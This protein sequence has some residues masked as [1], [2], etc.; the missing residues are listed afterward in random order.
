LPIFENTPMPLFADKSGKRRAPI[1]QRSLPQAGESLSDT[2]RERWIDMIFWAVLPIFLGTLCLGEWIRFW[3]KAPPSPGVATFVFV[4]GSGFCGWRALRIYR[5]LT[6]SL[7]AIRGERTVGELLETLR[8][9]GYRVFHD[10]TQEG[11][12]ID[13]AI[14]GPAGV[15]S[16]ETKTHSKPQ[17]GNPSVTFDGETILI[18]GFKPDR[19]PVVQAKASAGRVRKILLD[20]TGV[21][22]RVM[23]V[24][25]YPGW[26]V[27]SSV[28][29]DDI[30]VTNPKYFSKWIVGRSRKLSDDKINQLA[31]AM[32]S[33]L[34]RRE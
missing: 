2:V 26:W 4:A 13:H 12:N 29:G 16:I 11:Y 17:R 23:P 33:Y 28:K 10:I 21:E 7:M 9:S 25:L 15:M 32:D 27:D 18:D 20:N 34:R 3:T 5:D 24:V 19:D 31:A 14:I 6:P 30:L 8:S 1:E 22:I